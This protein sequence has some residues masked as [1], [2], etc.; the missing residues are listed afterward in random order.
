M[1]I[2]Y[3]TLSVTVNNE[4]K[5]LKINRSA[6]T[7]VSAVEMSSRVRFVVWFF[8]FKERGPERNFLVWRAGLLHLGED[9][10]SSR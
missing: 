8:F 3:S 2:C 5:N 6:G 7:R 9:R 4:E 10:Q 1:L